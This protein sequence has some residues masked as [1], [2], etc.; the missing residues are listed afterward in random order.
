MESPTPAA[1]DGGPRWPAPTVSP[2]EVVRVAMATR[3]V[4]E[5][6]RSDE[7]SDAARRRASTLYDRTLDQLRGILSP[8]LRRELAGLVPERQGDEPP[9]TDELRVAD[10]QLAGWLDGLL[11]SLQAAV[12]AQQQERRVEQADAAARAEA[13]EEAARR[14]RDTSYL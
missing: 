14:R 10:A 9:T 5:E 13:E 2:A 4:L 8:D 11:Q 1:D 3:E 12:V 7:M 6:L